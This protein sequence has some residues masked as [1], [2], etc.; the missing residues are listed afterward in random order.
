[1]AL[2]VTQKKWQV[3]LW[4]WYLILTQNCPNVEGHNDLKELAVDT[5]SSS[6]YSVRDQIG[7]YSQISI[8]SKR[9]SYLKMG[10]MIYS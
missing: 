8:Y 10:M 6:L 9:A 5:K 2:F 4:K 7:I 1:M 3:L